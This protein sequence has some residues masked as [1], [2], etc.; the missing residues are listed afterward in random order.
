MIALIVLIASNLL[1]VWRLSWPH[2]IRWFFGCFQMFAKDKN[3][4]VIGDCIVIGSRNKSN[5]S[6]GI[7]DDNW[8]IPFIRIT[9]FDRIY[10][11]T[12]DKR[13]TDF[14]PNS[15]YNDFFLEWMAIRWW[16]LPNCNWFLIHNEKCAK[17]DWAE[18]KATNKCS[19]Q[20]M[21]Q[22]SSV[23]LKKKIFIL[24]AQ[25]IFFF[26]LFHFVL[27]QWTTH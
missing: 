25:T 13:L 12:R 9:W 26:Y 18:Q 3:E 22:I 20:S 7:D 1:S 4:H 16:R 27:T 14:S 6:D 5:N 2:E 24:S 11:V 8:I 15:I 23:R 21:G 10:D 17:S 19:Q